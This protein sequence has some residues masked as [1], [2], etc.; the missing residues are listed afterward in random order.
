MY[1]EKV[2]V[3]KTIQ[4]Y[5]E[6]L[7]L[8]QKLWKYPPTHPDWR[9]ARETDEQTLGRWSLVG[10][11]GTCSS[12]ISGPEAAGPASATR[13][14]RC[15]S[16]AQKTRP[17]GWKFPVWLRRT[18]RATAWRPGSSSPGCSEPQF[19]KQEQRQQQTRLAWW[20]TG[21]LP[22][23]CSCSNEDVEG[24][25]HLQFPWLCVQKRNNTKSKCPTGSSELR[26]R[27]MSFPLNCAS[28]ISVIWLGV[29]ITWLSFSWG[30]FLLQLYWNRCQN[31][32][33]PAHVKIKK[34]VIIIPCLLYNQITVI[35]LGYLCSIFSW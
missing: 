9:T 14:T 15:Q 8:H 13:T 32:Q 4:C 30:F 17:S 2:R 23:N 33:T 3:K 22:A 24:A 27:F 18:M 35:L 10:S 28:F 6:T 1:W 16:R 12:H 7:T 34:Y 25:S 21:E 5:R 26:R 19:E 11:S 29:T 20:Q 31:K